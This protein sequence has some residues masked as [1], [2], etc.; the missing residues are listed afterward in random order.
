MIFF[1]IL[2]QFERLSLFLLVLGLLFSCSKDNP[3]EAL[4]PIAIEAVTGTA[5]DLRKTSVTLL[6]SILSSEMLPHVTEYGFVISTFN[7][8]YPHN[9]EMEIP[10]GKKI[11]T[12]EIRYTYKPTVPFDMNITY[13][14]CFYAKTA[15]GFYKG[16]RKT[17]KLDGL[18]V[19]TSANLMGMVGEKIVLQGDFSMIDSS[20]NLYCVADQSTLTSYS[21]GADGKT[22]TFK[23]PSANEL[24]HGKKLRV[25]LR[26]N[27]PMGIFDRLL[28]EV[29][30]LGAIDP[31]AQKTFLITDQIRFTGASLP[32]TWD[33][34]KTFEL[35]LGNV[36]IPFT[37]PLPI[38][39]LKGLT[40]NTFKIGFK[41]GRDSIVF[42]EEYTLKEPHSADIDFVE[43]VTHP[44]TYVT[45]KGVSLYDYFDPSTSTYTLG[46]YPINQHYTS[47]YPMYNFAI[48]DIPEGHYKLNIK[49]NIFSVQTAKTIQIKNF[50]WNSI[51]KNTAHVGEDVTLTGKFIKGF[52]YYLYSSEFVYTP[53]VS[54]EDGKLTF[55]VPAFAEDA[56]ELRIGHYQAQKDG[57]KLYLHDTPLPLKTL[58][59]SLDSFSPMSG[60]PGTLVKL[61]GKG[62]G[63]AYDIHLGD[64]KLFPLAYSADEV[65][66][67][68]PALQAKGKMRI[69]IN[70]YNRIFQSAEY[71]EII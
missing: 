11:P 36:T 7:G 21:I 31:P 58:G 45:V 71:F 25:Q 64:I 22:L 48:G 20:Y 29:L 42:P 68:I 43:Y 35:I 63:L 62:I 40:K 34:N 44:K 57:L 28:T 60:P 59:I 4:P 46:E 9:A 8:G 16:E 53:V 26:K 32:N 55:Q 70:S 61:K 17:F 51:D 54:T 23:I 56:T 14:Y 65:M 12:Q 41:N 2:K 50:E 27:S 15:K 5:D 6:G 30:I 52:E 49:S 67:T 33:N 39:S 66:V 69:V 19:E 47:N 3:D 13:S 1:R 38:K 37:N 24:S 10:L 18:Q